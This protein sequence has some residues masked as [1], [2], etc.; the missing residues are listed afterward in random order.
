MTAAR[1]LALACALATASAW[2]QDPVAALVS[3]RPTASTE[4]LLLNAWH[5]WQSGAVSEARSQLEALLQ[6]EPQFKLA[7]LLYG[8]LV[9][10]RSGRYPK[11]LAPDDPEVW[12]LR[13]EL[14]KRLLA[15]QNQPPADAVPA[16]LIHLAEPVSQL[17]AVDLGAGRLFLLE[18]QEGGWQRRREIFAGIGRE[19]FY[20]RKRGDLRTPVG[21]YRTGRFMADQELPELFGAGALTLDYP[22]AWDLTQK[23]DGDGIWI[24]GVP[25]DT[26]VR[27]PLSSE[28]CVTLANAEFDILRKEVETG[29]PVILAD[30]LQWSSLEESQ[31]QQLEW[32]DRLDQW[33]LARLSGDPARQQ[34]FYVTPPARP[35]TFNELEL[36]GI[37]VFRY[38]G[39]EK[40]VVAQFTARYQRQGRWAEDRIEQF[41]QQDGDKRWHIVLE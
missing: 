20:K 22:N 31:A 2:G 14:Q 3:G 10:G 24:H 17:I 18:R 13:L 36:E 29:T 8:D 1:R 27:A 37:S 23:R 26:Y 11:G 6:Q 33:R 25:R 9:A 41:W 21:I 4:A 40:M 12:P 16:G 30:A 15:E 39:E 28:G 32:L 34:A 7:W 5:Q 38:P 19:G 35:S